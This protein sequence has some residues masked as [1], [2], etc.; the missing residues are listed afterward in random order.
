MSGEQA[1]LI[2]WV[3]ELKLQGDE[4]QPIGNAFQ[5]KST[6]MNVD[7]LKVAIKTVMQ[8]PIAAPRIDIF[9]LTDGKWNKEHRMSAAL[10]DTDEDH[11]YG[12]VSP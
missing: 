9:C 10:H 7:D 2:A 12:Y 6:L 5:V 8:L 1:V 4:F 11:P 3:R